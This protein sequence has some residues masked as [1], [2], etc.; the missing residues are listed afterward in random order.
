MRYALFHWLH[1]DVSIRWNGLAGSLCTTLFSYGWLAGC[2]ATLR[3]VSCRIGS[4]VVKRQQEMQ[5]E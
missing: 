5:Y 3:S 1:A 4:Y 2:V